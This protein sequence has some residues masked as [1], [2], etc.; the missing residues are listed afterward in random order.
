[1]EF[2]Q[3]QQEYDEIFDQNAERKK[4]ELRK[5]KKEKKT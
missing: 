4:N 1:M 2:H 3:V 5:K